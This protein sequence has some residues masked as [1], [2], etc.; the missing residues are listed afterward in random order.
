MEATI[1]WM[2]KKPLRVG[3]SYLVQHG[4]NVSRSK[5]SALANLVD[6]VSLNALKAVAEL[7]LNETAD[8]QLRTAKETFYDPFAENKANG[9]F[10]VL[11]EQTNATIEVGLI[12]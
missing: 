8:V 2:D 11:D 10:T 9:A 6:V 4:I 5:V 12:R 7:N 3:S 1:C